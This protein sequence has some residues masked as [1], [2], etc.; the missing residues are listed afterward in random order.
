[1]ILLMMQYLRASECK[2]E[3]ELRTQQPV[4]IC[5]TLRDTANAVRQARYDA[6]VLDQ[7][8]LDQN[9][10]QADFLARYAGTAVTVFINPGIWGVDRICKEIEFA[11]ER[12]R[13]EKR[14]AE[15]AARNELKEQLSGAVTGILLS[16]ELALNS[17][18]LSPL[19]AEKLRSVRDLA[20]HMSSCLRQTLQ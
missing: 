18:S 20:L 14:I 11:L 2:D 10:G 4:T 17:E 19:V 12:A 15:Q 6:L 9:P 5:A 8:L 13:R 3:L 7:N 16:S 1:M